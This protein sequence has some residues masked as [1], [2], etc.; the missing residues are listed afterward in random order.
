MNIKTQASL[1]QPGARMT[2]SWMN[3]IGVPVNLFGE[4]YYIFKQEPM[5]DLFMLWSAVEL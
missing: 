1:D 2:W 4:K 3:V 5:L